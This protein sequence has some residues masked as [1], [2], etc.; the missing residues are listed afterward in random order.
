[1]RIYNE[2]I[3]QRLPELTLVDYP[4]AERL[5]NESE[6]MDDKEAIPL[7]SSGSMKQEIDAYV[8]LRKFS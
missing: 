2:Q 1:M 3:G 8:I 5:V 4:T 6:P 7:R